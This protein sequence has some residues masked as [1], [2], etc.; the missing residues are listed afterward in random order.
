MTALAPAS[1]DFDDPSGS[2]LRWF[3]GDTLAMTKRNL[4]HVRQVPEKL[5]DVTI[6]PIM[7]VVLFAYVF[8]GVIAVPGGNYREYLI[9]GILVQS[10][11]FGIMGPGVSI[12]TD[13]REGV[14]DRFRTM[15][16]SRSAYLVAHVVAE[17]A[18][19]SLAVI[20]LSLTGLVVGWRIHEDVAHAAAA[21]GLL[22]LFATAMICLGTLIGIVARTA[23]SVQGIAFIAVFPLTFMATTFVPLTG[24]SSGLRHVVEWNPISALAGAARTLFRNPTGIP[25]NAAWPMEHCVLASLLW[26]VAIIAVALPLAIRAFA[27]RTE[28]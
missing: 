21:Y 7:F 23:D 8:G 5:A 12:A 11:G 16:A 3:V 1:T 25:A 27:R 28:G 15:P 9:G 6:Q 13:L 19:I 18:A 24:F 2:R 4:A 20:L 17:L 10:L 26:C 14:V 22:M